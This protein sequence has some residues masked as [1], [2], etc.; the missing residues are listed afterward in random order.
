MEP[1]EIIEYA[2]RIAPAV[3]LG[4][5]P[6][7][8]VLLGNGTRAGLVELPDV[9]VDTRALAQSEWRRAVCGNVRRDE[10]DPRLPEAISRA[11]GALG[12]GLRCADW[13]DHQRITGPGIRLRVGVDAR[14]DLAAWTPRAPGT[15]SAEL[16]AWLPRVNARLRAARLELGDAGLRLAARF[17]GRGFASPVLTHVTHAVDC[18][19]A[20]VRAAIRTLPPLDELM[21]DGL[22][23]LLALVAS[24]EPVSVPRPS[25]KFR[26]GIPS[27]R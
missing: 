7:R 11:V 16:V 27:C 17:P 4:P 8:E 24:Q 20:A 6:A 15:S 22:Q 12:A 19:I 10:P 2:A 1:V 18:A 13:G 9:Y 5:G 26:K 3:A 21:T 23:P 14:G 25:S